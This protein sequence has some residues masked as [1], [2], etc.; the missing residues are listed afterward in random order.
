MSVSHP[1]VVA[2]HQMCVVRISGQNES[3]A[4]PATAP[5][6]PGSSGSAGSRGA[7]GSGGRLV[8]ALG[9]GSGMVEVVSPHDV[10]QP[11]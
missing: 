10:L 6:L 3:W 8:P 9:G 2:T 11:G 7:S 4:P 1:N 5:S